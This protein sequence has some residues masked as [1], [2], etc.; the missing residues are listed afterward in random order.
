MKKLLVSLAVS[1]PLVVG[2]MSVSAALPS[3]SSDRMDST[4]YVQPLAQVDQ[5]SA[6]GT[7]LAWW[8]H[9]GWHRGWHRGYWHRGWHHRGWHH[10]RYW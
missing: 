3:G 1:V 6:A 8:H 5:K 10:R 7:Q 4:T 2:S 9:R